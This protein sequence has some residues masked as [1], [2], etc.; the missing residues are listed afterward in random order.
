MILCSAGEAAASPRAVRCSKVASRRASR[1]VD[2]VDMRSAP[3]GQV[4]KGA[5]RYGKEAYVQYGRGEFVGKPITKINQTMNN[6]KA[7]DV[8]MKAIS[9]GGRFKL[10]L[11]SGE[12]IAIVGARPPNKPAP[13][14]STK[15]HPG[16]PSGDNHLA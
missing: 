11:S 16:G 10:H 8:Y 12:T 15:C 9:E 5:I 1:W 2:L 6:G 14:R 3:L 7:R 4:E 13:G